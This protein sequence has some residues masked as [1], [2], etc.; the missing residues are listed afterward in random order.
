MAEFFAS[1][2][3]IQSCPLKLVDVIKVAM[4]LLPQIYMFMISFIS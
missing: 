1:F 3:K 4:S 2:Q